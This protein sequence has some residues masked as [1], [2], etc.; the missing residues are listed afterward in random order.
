LVLVIRWR[1]RNWTRPAGKGRSCEGC[2][3]YLMGGRQN[4]RK[5][6]NILSFSP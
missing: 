4:G 1:R 2:H 6:A 5:T 3:E